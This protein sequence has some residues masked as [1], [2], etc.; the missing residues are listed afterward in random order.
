MRHFTTLL[1]ANTLFRAA[2][3]RRPDDLR[4]PV[5]SRQRA[6]GRSGILPRPIC[7]ARAICISIAT[8]RVPSP[9]MQRAPSFARSGSCSRNDSANSASMRSPS[10]S[11]TT[12]ETAPTRRVCGGSRA[13]SACATSRCSTGASRRGARPVCRSNNRCRLRRPKALA[14]SLDSD[15]WVSSET[16]DDLR[17]RPGNLLVDARGPSVLPVAT[18]R[19]IRSLATFPAR[20]TILFSPISAPTEN[21]CLPR[22]CA[23]VSAP[24]SAPHR[25]PR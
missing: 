7:P 22:S 21:S 10:S 11:P 17:Q 23:R 3:A 16:V 15:A 18:R 1:D 24:C 9:P 20:E 5:R 14:A 6:M 13:G 8:S 19:S 2:F 4:L 12:R 25:L